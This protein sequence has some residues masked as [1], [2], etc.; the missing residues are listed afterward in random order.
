MNCLY[1]ELYYLSLY[2]ISK[3]GGGGGGGGGGELPRTCSVQFSSVQFK[4]VKQSEAK[5]VG[6]ESSH[7]EVN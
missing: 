1:T 4:N 7:M 6:A 3:L 5:S 2:R